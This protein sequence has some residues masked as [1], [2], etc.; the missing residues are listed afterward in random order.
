MEGD[1]NVDAQC[2][3]ALLMGYGKMRMTA[4]VF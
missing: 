3:K 2:S 4:K 1:V